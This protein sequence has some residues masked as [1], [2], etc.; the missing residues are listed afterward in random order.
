LETIHGYELLGEWKNSNSGKIAKGV[1]DGKTYFIKKYL[2]PVK[3]IDNG[4]MSAKTVERNERIFNQFVALRTRLNNALRPVACEGSN[5]VIP[6]EEF[7]E[8]NHYIEVSEAIEGVVPYDEWENVL[9]SLS[10]D[11]KKLLMLTAAGGVGV[12]HAQ[13]IIHGDLKFENVLLTRNPRS[14]NYVAKIIDFDCACFTEDIP[15]ESIGDIRYLS[16]ELAEYLTEEEDREPLRA[17]ITTKTD[18]F[19][20]GIIFHRYLAGEFPQGK[21]LSKALQRRKESGR[22]IYCW[23]VLL[24]GGALEISDTITDSNMRRLLAAML[25]INPEK[26]PTA[27]EVLRCLK[28][29]R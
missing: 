20:L 3:P 15:D 26:R 6:T 7:I 18:I 23:A 14:G 19:S 9:A 27:V 16:P 5:I 4:A 25:D 10:P 2:S 17:K 21:N 28:A 12:I 11:V 1:K 29:W 8:G 13:Q 22:P 24:S